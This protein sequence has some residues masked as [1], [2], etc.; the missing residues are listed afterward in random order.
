MMEYRMDKICYKLNSLAV[1]ILVNLH[2]MKFWN[3]NLTYF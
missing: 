3:K 2:F 1:S